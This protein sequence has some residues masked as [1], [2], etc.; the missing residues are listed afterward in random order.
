MNNRRHDQIAAFRVHLALHLNVSLGRQ[1]AAG[2]LA[3]RG[4]SLAVALRVLNRPATVRR[5]DTVTP[6]YPIRSDGAGT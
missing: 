4:V 6:C 2:F 3:K 5:E 1:A